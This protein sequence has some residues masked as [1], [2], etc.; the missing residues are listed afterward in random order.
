MGQ[1]RHKILVRTAFL[2]AITL[3]FQSLRFIM[4]V[5]P[6]FSTFIIGSLVNACLLVAL[7]TA[8]LS[9]AIILAVMT[10][11]IAY[12]QQLLLLPVFILPVAAANIIYISLFKAGNIWGW[13]QGVG[14]A[15]VGKTIF[16]WAIFA[17]LL[18]FI[19]I[20]PKLAS[21]LLFVMSWPQLVTSVLGGVVATTVVRR[22]NIW[23]K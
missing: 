4:P 20:S 15:A 11:V 18:T 5:P 13:W 12:F 14:L 16:L 23:L 7:E 19:A 3:M 6:I 10:P 9:G 8:G 17:W 2:L 22:L 1:T 21:A